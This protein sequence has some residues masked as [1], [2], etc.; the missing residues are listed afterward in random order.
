[1]SYTSSHQL[2]LG[3]ELHP[4][5]TVLQYCSGALDSIQDDLS[6]QP[7]WPSSLPIKR[8]VLNWTH[9]PRIH[10]TTC[11]HDLGIGLRSSAFFWPGLIS[12]FGTD[13]LE[14]LARCK[15]TLISAWMTVVS[16]CKGDLSSCNLAE[17]CILPSCILTTVHWKKTAYDRRRLRPYN[18]DSWPRQI[19]CAVCDPEPS[20]AGVGHRYIYPKR[21]G[22]HIC[23]QLEQQLDPIYYPDAYPS[24]T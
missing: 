24:E 2:A 23:R 18:K 10:G 11:G 12:Y 3:V 21:G 16:Q 6:S 4:E 8:L 13:E 22:R 9:R 5:D 14:E 20:K 19:L 7:S 15:Y 17:G 1:M